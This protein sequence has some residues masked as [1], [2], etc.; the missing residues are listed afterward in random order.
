MG[1]VMLVTI[2]D[3]WRRRM[4]RRKADRDHE[5]REFLLEALLLIWKL[6]IWQ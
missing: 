1:L 2:E 6:W 4:R 3:N 5:N